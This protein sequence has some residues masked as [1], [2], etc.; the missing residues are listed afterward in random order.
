M[1]R[2]LVAGWTLALLASALFTT[3]GF[4]QLQRGREKQAMLTQVAAVLAERRA[5]PLAAAA[6]P[7]R[8]RAFDWAAGRGRFIDAPAVL[9]DNQQ[10]GGR[11][12]VRAYRVFAPA[13]DAT[14]L[15]VDLGWLPLSGA[16]RMPVVA[17]LQGSV[18]IQ[19]LLAPPP[20]QGITR[21]VAVPQA[22]GALLTIGLDTGTLRQTLRQPQLAPR[23]LKLDPALPLGYARD[24]DALPNTLPPQRHLGYAVQWFALALAVLVTAVVLSLRRPAPRKSSP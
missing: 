4:W 15:L 10:R 13:E 22:D 3:L 11:A 12:G 9:L 18:R 7:A 16:R 24:L 19:G 23:V 2:D 14:P 17:R 21:A 1:R 20:S 8:A 6:D 5:Q